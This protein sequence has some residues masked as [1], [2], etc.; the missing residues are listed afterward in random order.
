M[1]YSP[2]AVVRDA[3]G[4]L[5]CSTCMATIDP[6]TGKCADA[7]AID[8]YLATEMGKALDRWQQKLADNAAAQGRTEAY[9]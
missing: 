5:I 8:R 2:H 6:E 4:T 9:W 1:I 7:Q 3:D